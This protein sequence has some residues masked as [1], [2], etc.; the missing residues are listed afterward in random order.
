MSPSASQLPAPSMRGGWFCIP[1][2]V[3]YE[4]TDAGGIV[5]YANYLKY[6]ERGRTELLRH[7]GI[8]QTALKSESGLIFAVSDCQIRYRLP[9]R[10]D[11]LLL[12]KTKVAALGAA[13]IEMVQEIVRDEVR[14]TE[15]GVTV[16]SINEAGR[17]L[18]M[19]GPLRAVLENAFDEGEEGK[20]V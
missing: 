6:A 8:N 16:A 9:A 10:L 14:L 5:Y 19:P 18:R 7:L 15:I 2:R 17:P 3:Y 20:A 1:L 11:D 13:R 4:D 12:V